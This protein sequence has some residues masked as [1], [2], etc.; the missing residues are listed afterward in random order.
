MENYLYSGMLQKQKK[1]KKKQNKKNKLKNKMIRQ[2]N[3]NASRNETAAEISS[4][5]LTLEQ[6]LLYDTQNNS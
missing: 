3:E 5:G 4:N 2:K 6:S 1:T